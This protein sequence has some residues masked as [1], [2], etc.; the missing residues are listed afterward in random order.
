MFS[1]FFHIGWVNGN[2]SNGILNKGLNRMNEKAISIY[3]WKASKLNQINPKVVIKN[4]DDINRKEGDYN[5]ENN[6]V[7]L[8]RL[9]SDSLP[10]NTLD[11]FYQVIADEIRLMLVSE[12]KIQILQ[13]SYDL[14]NRIRI[15]I[16]QLAYKD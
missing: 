15:A 4:M 5:P 9:F 7:N 8:A 6:S 14:E 2:A 11:Y 10:G 3:T 12:D 1:W 13:S 16:N